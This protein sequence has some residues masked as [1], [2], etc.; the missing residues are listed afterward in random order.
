MSKQG[1]SMHKVKEILRLYFEAQLSQHQIARS[2]Q[3][4]SGAVNKYLSLFRV[5]EINWPLA[6]DMD[7]TELRTLLRPHIKSIEKNYFEPDYPSIHQELKSKGVTLLLLWQEYEQ[8]HKKS[9][10]RYAQFCV[11]YKNWLK[12]QKP[13]MRQIHRAGEK[14]FIDYCCPTID[15]I[16]PDH[17]EI[18]SAAI[19]VA[20]LGASK[21]T[22]VEATW[23]QSLPNWVASHVRAF[24]F[25]GGVPALLVPDNLKSAV[26]KACRY[27]PKINDT[28]ADLATHYGTAVL[29]ARPYKP[30]DKSHAEN[31]VLITERW[32]LARLRKQTFVGLGELNLAISSL[33]K[34][35]NNRPFKKLPGTRFSQFEELDK[36]LLKN[37]PINTYELATFFKTRAYQNYHIKADENYYSVPYKLINQLIQVRLT[38][39]TIECFY[40]GQRIA[41]HIRSYQKGKYTTLLEHLPPAHKK[42]SQWNVEYFLN[43]AISIGPSVNEVIK[44]LLSSVTY[45]EQNYRACFGILK[46]VKKYGNDRLESACKRAIDINSPKYHTI[47]SILQKGLDKQPLPQFITATSVPKHNNIRGAGHYQNKLSLSH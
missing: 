35:L 44:L 46:G 17:G 9:A 13:S 15:I 4:S 10:Y 25:F 16:D 19:F 21:Y 31:S 14:L 6:K 39:N 12:Q 20:V 37:L 40:N 45:P 28:Y 23:D 22:Y 42:F 36:P 47:L 11:K 43:W 26:T 3:L 2:L 34:E 27:E 24:Q 18:R 33:L 41:T 7:E 8:T 1:V 29:P 30:K 38:V 32:I 5:A